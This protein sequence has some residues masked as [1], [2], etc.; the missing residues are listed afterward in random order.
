VDYVREKIRAKLEKRIAEKGFIVLFWTD[1]GWVRYFSRKPVLMPDDLRK[2]KLFGWAS[3]GK[4][5]EI[6]KFVGFQPIPLET[7][8]ILPGL[9][10]GLIDAV[11]APPFFALAGQFYGPC[12]NMLDLNVSPLAGALVITKK[13][14]DALPPATQKVMRESAEKAGTDIR[15]Q[16]RKEMEESVEAMKKRGMKV[17]E[18]TPEATAAWQKVAESTYPKI[19]GY[20]VPSDL[21]DEVL[22]LLTEYRAV[23]K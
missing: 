5:N 16:A 4:A 22:Q 7:A 18:L 21:F 2:Q 9:Q 6:A 12:P 3:D 23:K 14:W 8:D 19:R 13:A 11:P 17:H 15:K 1:A 10:T 20:L